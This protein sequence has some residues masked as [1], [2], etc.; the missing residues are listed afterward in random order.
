MDYQ[1]FVDGDKTLLIAP[2]G[3]GKTHTIAECLKYTTGRQLILTHTHAGVASIKEKIKKH[4]IASNRYNVETISSF[5]QKYVTSFYLG[6]DMPDQENAREYHPFIIDKAAIIFKSNPIRDVIKATYAGLF[7]DEY[8]DCTKPQHEMILALSESLRT[9][10]LGDPL[11]G[12]FNFNGDLVDFD[13]DLLNFVRA[14]ELSTP[15]RWYQDGN[16]GELGERLKEVRTLL[17]QEDVIDFS[18]NDIEG[19]YIINVNSEDLRNPRSEY[20]ICLNKLISNPDNNPD[21]DSLLIIV[22]EYEEVKSNGQKVPKGDIRDRAQIRV[23]IDYSKSLTLLEAIDDR[24]FYSLAKKIDNLNASIGRARKPIKKIKEDVLDKIFYKSELDNWFNENGIKNKRN[25]ADKITAG[26]LNGVINFYISNPLPRNM[27][28]IIQELKNNLKIK[29]K[30]DGLLYA[31]LKTLKQDSLEEIS[32]YEAMKN[33][34]NVIR[35]SGRKITGKCIGTTLLT[36]GLE[37]DT[38]AII[39]AHKF[40]CPKHLYVA[41]TRCCKNLYIFSSQSTLSPY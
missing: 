5:A 10:I 31:I 6:T 18:S 36:K 22:P 1:A 17:E 8:Q 4:S 23:Q 28:N 9:H 40:D 25:D 11:Q 2:A 26:T 14:P 15:H 29:Y 30:R 32:V 3:Y 19:L 20:R 39:D 33:Y 24:S 13:T 41:L 34:R 7:V 37:F 35:R 38:V 21:F 27:N 16:N 12:I